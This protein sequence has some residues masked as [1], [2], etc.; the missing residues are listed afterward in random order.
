MTKEIGDMH[1]HYGNIEESRDVEDAV[2][3]KYG[4]RMP[5]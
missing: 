4:P 3:Y 2:P 5:K 1:P